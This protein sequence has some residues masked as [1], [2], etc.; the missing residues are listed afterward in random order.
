MLNDRSKGNDH[1]HR[2]KTFQGNAKRPPEASGGRL[3]VVNNFFA[4]Y[5][6]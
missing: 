3:L 2:E 4:P 1:V 6:D 5:R